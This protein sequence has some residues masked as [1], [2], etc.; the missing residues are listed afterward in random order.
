MHLCVLRS[1]SPLLMLLLRDL[2]EIH[3]TFVL[4]P[5]HSSL[6]LCPI[7][8]L[9]LSIQLS[10]HPFPLLPS[11]IPPFLIAVSGIKPELDFLFLYVALSPR[12]LFTVPSQSLHPLPVWVHIKPSVYM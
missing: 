8:S 7:I 3:G 9:F 2:T 12:Y 6:P 4:H 1:M 5:H 10:L 11:S